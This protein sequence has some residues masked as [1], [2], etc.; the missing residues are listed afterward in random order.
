MIWSHR[1][2]SYSHFISVGAH[3]SDQVEVQVERDKANPGQGTPVCRKTTR[4]NYNTAPAAHKHTP[5][6][7]CPSTR[8]Y[9]RERERDRAREKERVCMCVPL[10]DK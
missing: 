4:S 5:A 2:V 8:V 3:F 1:S 10:F 6:I 9:M 7:A